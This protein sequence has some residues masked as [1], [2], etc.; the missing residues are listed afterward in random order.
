MWYDTQ[1]IDCGNY[2]SKT[3]LIL[4]IAP[5]QYIAN[6]LADLYRTARYIARAGVSHIRLKAD[7]KEDIKQCLATTLTG[8]SGS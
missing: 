5:A 6:L 7:A 8:G 4:N 3:E 2:Y 1:K